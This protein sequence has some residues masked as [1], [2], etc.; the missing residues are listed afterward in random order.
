MKP[1]KNFVWF[2]GDV[3]QLP[4]Y[5]FHWDGNFI[6]TNEK[7]LLYNYSNI[8]IRYTNGEDAIT[9]LKRFWATFPKLSHTNFHFEHFSRNY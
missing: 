7:F 1:I 8:S 4:H 5:N 6:K 2:E 3:R 9:Y